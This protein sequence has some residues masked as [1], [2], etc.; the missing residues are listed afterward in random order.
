MAIIPKNSTFEEFSTHM[1]KQR[2]GDVEP[3][4]LDEIWDRF[5]R[6]NSL[7]FATGRGF[8]SILPD[9]EKGLTNRER[10]NKMVAEAEAQ[11]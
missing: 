6:F 4:E 8:Q 2:G 1:R 11:G 9:D 10:E 5:K 3:S 7:S